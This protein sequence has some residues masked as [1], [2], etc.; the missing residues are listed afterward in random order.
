M[1]TDE[2]CLPNPWGEAA[3]REELRSPFGLLLVLEED[4][5]VVGH[6]A[7]KLVADEL[8]I[9]T[10]AV[11][12]EHRRRGCA[13]ALVDGAFARS[14]NARH[15]HLEVRPSNAAAHALYLSLGFSEVGRRPR[16][17]GDEDA[18]LMSR[19]LGG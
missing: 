6:I 16:Y 10:L 14:P 1:K 18:V 15:A 5:I 3:W 4:G 7:V 2:I 12:P 8:H 13:R 9:T 11:R 17:Y 19:K